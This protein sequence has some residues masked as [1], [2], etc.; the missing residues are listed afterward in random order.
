MF[1]E[2]ILSINSNIKAQ[3][4]DSGKYASG[5]L[6]KVIAPRELTK[7]RASEPA[8][9]QV[10]ARVCSN[11][12][13]AGSAS[14]SQDGVGAAARVGGN[15]LHNEPPLP[16]RGPHQSWGPRKGRVVHCVWVSVIFRGK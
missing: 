13:S 9:K 11:F 15:N 3:E 12:V 5:R 1:D 7:Q 6:L 16:S 10:S 8:S 2:L 14:G 4:T